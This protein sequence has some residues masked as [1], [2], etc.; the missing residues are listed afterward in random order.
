MRTAGVASASGT[1]HTPNPSCGICVPSFRVT[2]GMLLTGRGAF[3]VV[4]WF[5]RGNWCPGTIVPAVRANLRRSFTAAWRVAGRR[6]PGWRGRSG[7][8]GAAGR[9][10]TCCVDHSGLGRLTDMTS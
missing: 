9:R 2:L 7:G 8:G 1:C 5:Q 3:L 6:R 4:R 10:K